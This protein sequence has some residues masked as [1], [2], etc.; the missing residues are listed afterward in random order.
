MSVAA[1]ALRRGLQRPDIQGG[2]PIDVR[3][4]NRELARR[5][6]D[7]LMKADPKGKE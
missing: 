1:G 5:M 3:V 2:K 7:T 6:L 4:D